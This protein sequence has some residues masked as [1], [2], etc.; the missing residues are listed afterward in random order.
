MMHSR[1][2]DIFLFLIF[3]LLLLTLSFSRKDLEPRPGTDTAYTRSASTAAASTNGVRY[4]TI[5]PLDGSE[6]RLGNFC[7]RYA[8]ALGIAAKNNM[9]LVLP[10]TGFVHSM[11]E[12]FN[13]KVSG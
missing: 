6:G 13:V 9:T 1:Q 2:K 12:I 5:T 4:L 7:F 11:R 3:I 8:A 10:A